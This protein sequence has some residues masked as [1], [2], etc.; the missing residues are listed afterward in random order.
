V[1]VFVFTLYIYRKIHTLTLRRTCSEAG[2]VSDFTVTIKARTQVRVS[3]L[4]YTEDG[5]NRGLPPQPLLKPHTL[6]KHHPPPPPAPP[7]TTP[8]AMDMRGGGGVGMGGQAYAHERWPGKPEDYL[9]FRTKVQILTLTRLLGVPTP[10]QLRCFSCAMV[11][12]YPPN[13]LQV[14]CPSCG[15]VNSTP[16]AGICGLK[17]QVYAALS[18]RP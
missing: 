10:G 16:D 2:L 14:K 9:F 13:V 18:M 3:S 1:F 7:T 15:T 4:P 5:A 12:A 17:L 6:P 8:A 11:M